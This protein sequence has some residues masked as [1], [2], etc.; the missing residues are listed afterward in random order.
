MASRSSGTRKSSARKSTRRSSSSSSRAKAAPTKAPA[1][2]ADAKPQSR[3]QAES[4]RRGVQPHLASGPGSGT[5]L[6]GPPEKGTG[7]QEE[8]ANVLD[9]VDDAAD[10][11]V[12][13]KDEVYELVLAPGTTDRYIQRVLWPKGKQVRRSVLER[14]LAEQR[15]RAEAE[16][17]GK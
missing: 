4:E 5:T 10:P 6:L 2:R 9:L 17:G 14:H 7:K 15:K 1:K 8:I 11:V 13:L 16:E 12:I 3:E